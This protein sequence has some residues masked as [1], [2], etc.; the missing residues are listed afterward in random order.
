M[1]DSWLGLLCCCVNWDFDNLALVDLF[2]L[3]IVLHSF[4]HLMLT[5]QAVI[6]LRSIMAWLA[7]AYA[8]GA[9]LLVTYSVQPK[10]FSEHRTH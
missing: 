3:Q 8:T 10:I 4:P 5:L 7:R 2:A 9:T 6:T 1:T